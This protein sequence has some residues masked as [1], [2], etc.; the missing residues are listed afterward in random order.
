MF[1]DA[2][3]NGENIWIEND[4][5][6][7]ESHFLGQDFK[8]T[9]ANVDFAFNGIR[10]TAFVKCHDDDGGAVCASKSR[11]FN[12]LF[13]ALFQADRVHNRLALH[14]TKPCFDDGPL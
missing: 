9:F 11:Q 3:C 5:R 6:G 7:I 2:G 12:E 14:A 10:L 13:L 4:I 8:G 1:F